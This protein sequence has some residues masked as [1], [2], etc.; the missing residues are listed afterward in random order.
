M[1]MNNDKAKQFEGTDKAG[2]TPFKS[3]VGKST[4]STEQTKRPV[5]NVWGSGVDNAFNTAHEGSDTDIHSGAIHHTLG[6]G[7][8]QAAP[9]NA[10]FMSGDIKL[11][12]DREIPKGWLSCDGAFYPIEKYPT[13]FYLIG[14]TYGGVVGS[15]FAVPSIDVPFIDNALI[16][17][18]NMTEDLA[19]NTLI[20]GNALLENRDTSLVLANSIVKNINSTHGVLYDFIQNITAL[21]SIIAEPEPHPRPDPDPALVNILSNFYGLLSDLNDPDLELTDAI[22]E[23]NNPKPDLDILMDKLNNP[24]YDDDNI[25][26]VLYVRYIIKI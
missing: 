1:A 23:L 2:N 18:V 21:I 15:T 11:A 3:P 16:D 5:G 24:I 4:R 6:I 13:L 9:G 10:G 8:F 17:I 7:S 20:L 25:N 14:N 19:S 22:T 12:T 26:V